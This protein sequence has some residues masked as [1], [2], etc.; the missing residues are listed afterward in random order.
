MRLRGENKFVKMGVSVK[1][2]IFVNFL[3]LYVHVV[4]LHF[5]NIVDDRVQ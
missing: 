1:R 4:Y 2:V 3:V 5:I